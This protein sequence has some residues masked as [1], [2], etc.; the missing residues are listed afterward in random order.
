MEW[1]NLPDTSTPQS[2]ENLND[3]SGITLFENISSGTT[4]EIT[5]PENAT[6]YK[7]IDIFFKGNN[8]SLG[9]TRTI[10]G[11]RTNLFTANEYNNGIYQQVQE[12][13]FS[14]NILKRKQSKEINFIGTSFSINAVPLYIVKVVGYK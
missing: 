8:G 13:Y 11:Q 5:L 7:C 3:I 14:N 12:I 4:G 9:Y 6:N 1:K 2:A 10:G